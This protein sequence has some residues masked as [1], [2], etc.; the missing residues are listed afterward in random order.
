MTDDAFPAHEH[1]DLNMRHVRA[2][3]LTTAKTG[4]SHNRHRRLQ[5]RFV[6]MLPVPFRQRSYM[7]VSVLREVQNHI[8]G[9]GRIANDLVWEKK[10]VAFRTRQSHGESASNLSHF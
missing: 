3:S 2:Y 8:V 4:A 9:R 5:R 1:C 10:P 7:V 6:E